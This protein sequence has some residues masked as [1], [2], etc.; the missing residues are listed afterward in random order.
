M[1]KPNSLIAAHLNKFCQ[2]ADGR[3]LE[4]KTFTAKGMVEARA[5]IKASVIHFEVHF[6]SMLDGMKQPSW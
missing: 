4:M 5:T 1:D 3:S 2:V 6:E